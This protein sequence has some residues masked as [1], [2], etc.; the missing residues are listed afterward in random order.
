[1]A[2][3]TFLITE[4]V[5]RVNTVLYKMKAITEF[6]FGEEWMSKNIFT[7]LKDFTMTKILTLVR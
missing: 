2:L 1:M 3:Y 4:I 5:N 6:L 7:R